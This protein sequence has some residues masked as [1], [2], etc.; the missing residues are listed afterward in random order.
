M[1]QLLLSHGLARAQDLHAALLGPERMAELRRAE[2]EA[3]KAR[4]G[5]WSTGAAAVNG[6]SKGE[7]EAMVTRIWSAD[8]ISVRSTTDDQERRLALSSV[9]AVRAT[10]PKLAGIAVEAREF[11]RKRLIGKTVRITTDF[12]TKPGEHGQTEAR[13]GVTARLPNGDNVAEM[14]IERGLATVIRHRRDDED[15]STDIDLLHQAE[16]RAQAE[17]KGLHS[18]K[19]VPAPRHLDASETHVRATSFLGQF[20]RGRTPAIIDFVSS[21]SRFKLLLPKFEAK[22]TLV[23]AGVRAP[24]APR[25]AGGPSGNAAMDKGDP[26]GAE[27]LDFSSRRLLQRDVEVQVYDVDR[28]GGFIGAIFLPKP[29]S[30]PDANFAVQLVRAGLA[31]VDERGAGSLAFGQELRDAEAEA[32]AG[33]KGLWHS[34]DADAARA[35]AAASQ[36]GPITPKAEIIELVVSDIR[37]DGSFSV[38]RL[39]NGQLPALEQFVREFAAHHATPA[40][41]SAQPVVPRKGE[42]VSAKFSAD[43]AWYRARIVSENQGKRT[44]DVMFVDYGACWR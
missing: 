39:T 10:D 42:L 23:L 28:S 29:A 36:A 16:A 19:D 32:Q 20:K 34:Y 2:T 31:S 4:R 7:T 41:A 9:R 17:G 26:M 33:R 12:T 44:A 24:R 5:V 1:A 38:Q 6:S 8:T 21:G 27:A 14:V 13:T 35:Q 25:Q 40:A 30:G 37:D 3:K 15:K 11:L 43:G 22:A 18:G